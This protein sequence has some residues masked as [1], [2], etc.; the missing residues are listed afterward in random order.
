[1]SDLELEWTRML[2]EYNEWANRRSLSVAR[3]LSPEAFA[4]DLGSS[5]RSVQGTLRH[6]MDIEALWLSR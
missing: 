4:R 2:Y 1:M 6:I 5:Y 3:S